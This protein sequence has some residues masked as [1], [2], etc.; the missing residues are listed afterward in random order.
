MACSRRE[1]FFRADRAARVAGEIFCFARTRSGA[2]PEGVLPPN[3][4]NQHEMRPPIGP[5]CGDPVVVRI[6]QTFER[7]RPGLEAGGRVAGLTQRI[8]PVRMT[9][10]WLK[11]G[12]P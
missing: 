11:H 4:P 9:R 8:W 10:F 12:A 6:F 3:A 5:R 1:Y 7:P 2:E